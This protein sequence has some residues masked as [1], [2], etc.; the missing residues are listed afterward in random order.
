VTGLSAAFELAV[1]C[2]SIRLAFRGDRGRRDSRTARFWR[3]VPA[4]TGVE[5]SGVHPHL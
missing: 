3:T 1:F 4:P 5:L 2:S